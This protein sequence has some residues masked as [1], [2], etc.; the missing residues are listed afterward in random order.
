MLFKIKVMEPT[1]PRP[2][3]LPLDARME[4]CSGVREPLGE[5]LGIPCFTN[6]ISGETISEIHANTTLGIRERLAE[7]YQCP[8]SDVVLLKSGE[9]VN[10]DQH[11]YDDDISVIILKS[12]MAVPIFWPSGLPPCAPKQV[13]SSTR[14]LVTSPTSFIQNTVERLQGANAQIY[15]NFQKWQLSIDYFNKFFHHCRAL[16]MV[17]DDF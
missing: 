12:S 16:V 13:A 11:I 5:V 15:V 6:A 17:F 14:T 10:N 4:R 9:V 3:Y 2:S 8:S 1:T 7:L